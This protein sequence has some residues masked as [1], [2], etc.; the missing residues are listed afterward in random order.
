MGVEGLF[1]DANEVNSI[2]TNKSYRDDGDTNG[3][4]GQV[5]DTRCAIRKLILIVVVGHEE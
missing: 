4:R 3:E 1:L 2:D 5:S